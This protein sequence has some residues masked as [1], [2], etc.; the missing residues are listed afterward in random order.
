MSASCLS[1]Y[2]LIRPFFSTSCSPERN[3][4]PVF[5]AP[6]PN[7]RVQLSFDKR[8]RQDALFRFRSCRKMHGRTPIE[9]DRCIAE[10]KATCGLCL[11]LL[12]L[13]PFERHV[14]TLC[15]YESRPGN[16][17]PIARFRF[18][19][20]LSPFSMAALEAATQRRASASRKPFLRRGRAATGWAGPAPALG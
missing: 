10:I 11:A 18:S 17:Y 7:N 1:V 5:T 4:A 8:D 9:Q 13:I 19:S 2:R 16:T 14:Y 20:I 15:L 3:D 6:S 12:G